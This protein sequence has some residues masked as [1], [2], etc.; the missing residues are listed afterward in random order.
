MKLKK[1]LGGAD[2]DEKELMKPSTFQSQSGGQDVS[3][4]QELNEAGK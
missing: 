1:I 3:L 2:D 4:N